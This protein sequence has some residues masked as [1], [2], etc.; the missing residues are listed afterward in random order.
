MAT[1]GNVGGLEC[2]NPWR[3][4]ANAIVAQAAHDYI[5]SFSDQ[6]EK[7]IGSDRI[8]RKEVLRFFHSGWYEYL[9]GIDPG[10]LIN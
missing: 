5:E 4:L 8:D 6:N 10:Y 3:N 2:G 9:T 1:K 7:R